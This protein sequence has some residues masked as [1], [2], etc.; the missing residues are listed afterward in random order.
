ML[1]AMD[2]ATALTVLGLDGRAEWRQIR[3][4]HRNAIRRSHPDTGGS[5]DVAARVNEAFDVLADATDGGSRPLPAPPAA[6]QPSKRS[7][8]E[9]APTVM[10]S[11]SPT[12]LLLSLADVG[13]DVGAV[14]FV[15]PLAGLL[16]II[17]G[18]E[19]GVGQLTVAVG[20]PTD[21]GVRVSFTLEPLGVA[22]PPPIGEV[23][24]DLLRRHRARSAR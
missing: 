19:P 22:T 4:A 17:V 23:V 7:S 9:S 6:T 18:A 24:D 2:I 13:H 16:E 15:D 21:D 12:E 5:T 11:D 10:R 1:G 14:V 20:E 3:T 8:P